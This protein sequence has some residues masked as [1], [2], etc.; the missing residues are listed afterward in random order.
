MYN[1]PRWVRREDTVNLGERRVY[2][3][4]NKRSLVPSWARIRMGGRR[5]EVDEVEERE[6]RTFVQV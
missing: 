1:R 4:S 5:R 3:C 2:I 6:C